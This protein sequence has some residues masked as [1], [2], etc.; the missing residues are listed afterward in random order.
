M[1]LLNRLPPGS[2]WW[3][4][5]HELRLFFYD[6]GEG[7]K[8]KKGE[9][10]KR[11]LS[12][13]AKLVYGSA[14]LVVHLLVWLVMRKMPPLQEQPSGAIL[15]IAG[16]C[17]LL[18]FSFMISMA[19]NR[20]VKALF[21]RGDLD[22]LLSSPIS[23]RSIFTVRLAGVV[24]GVAL[25][26]L[27][28]LMPVANVGLLMGQVRWSGIYPTLLGCATLASSLAMLATL[29]LVK[30]IGVRRTLVTAQLLGALA[31]A[32]FFILSQLFG[33]ANVGFKEQVMAQVG[34]WFQAGA[35]LGPDSIIWIPAKAL[36][37]SPVE[38]ALFVGLAGLSFWL[39]AHYTHGFFVRGLQQSTAIARQPPLDRADA[40]SSLA[41][42]Q[43]RI[44]KVR[45]IEGVLPN[46]LRKEWRLILRDPQ[47]ISQ[48]LLQLLYTFP[49]F[50]IIFKDR[51]LLPGVGGALTYLAGSLAASLIWIIISAEDA[52]DLL[53]SSPVGARKIRNVKL[54][55]A[56]LPVLL[57]FLPAM[58]WLAL[59]DLKSAFLMFAGCLGAMYSTS[60]IHL[61]LAKPASRTE[62]NRRV[63]GSIALALLESFGNLFW[64]G[65]VYVTSSFGWWGMIPLALALAMLG[66]AWLL[67]IKPK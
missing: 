56:V 8:N 16:G 42:Q 67:R 2:S 53:S 35:V 63:N 48:I 36:F 6:L 27:L 23:S 9:H 65:F 58:V 66:I 17:M 1:K 25:L 52:A 40:A 28:L 26:A 59:N 57:L 50:F 5:L 43:V 13:S 11:G 38:M 37:G 51:V 4:L 10:V 61:Y 22:L 41:A 30:L 31:G 62:F 39:T 46:V 24:L 12:L 18:V 7:K 29:G 32:G 54:L 19:V 33:N 44:R 20:S 60:L 45:F 55:A 21:E 49:I 14:Y 3:L 47:L 34:P 15:M 64:A